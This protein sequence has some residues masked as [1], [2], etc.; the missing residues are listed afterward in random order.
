[1]CAVATAEAGAPIGVW[2]RNTILSAA[3]TRRDALGT[4]DGTLPA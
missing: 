1:M 3:R 4:D 2:V